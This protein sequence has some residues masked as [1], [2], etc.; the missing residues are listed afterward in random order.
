MLLVLALISIVCIIIG[1]RDKILQKQVQ[2]ATE[3]FEEAKAVLVDRVAA[4]NIAHYQMQIDLLENNA[5]SRLKVS[6]EFIQAKLSEI[7]KSRIQAHHIDGTAKL[8]GIKP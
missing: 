6:N 1:I 5:K 3:E 8:L 7:E 2:Q 4:I